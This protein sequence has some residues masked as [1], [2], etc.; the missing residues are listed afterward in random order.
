MRSI[1]GKPSGGVGD[2][3]PADIIDGRGG[4]GDRGLDRILDG[5]GRGA[6]ELDDL[7]NMVAH[8][9]PSL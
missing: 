7:V 9:L 5:A 8:E 2:F 6:D 3:E 4:A 1:V